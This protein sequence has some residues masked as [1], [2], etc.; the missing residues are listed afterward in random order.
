MKY[1]IVGEKLDLSNYYVTP[2]T[3]LFVPLRKFKSKK[4]GDIK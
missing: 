2:T 1:T 3:V 4:T